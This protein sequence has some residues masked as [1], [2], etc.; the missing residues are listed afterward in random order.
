MTCLDFAIAKGQSGLSSSLGSA[1]AHQ[2]RERRGQ[3]AVAPPASPAIAEF[4]LA[5]L[6]DASLRVLIPFR[7]RVE[8]V[9]DDPAGGF[10]AIAEEI[11]EIG[12]GE[13][14]SEAITDLAT[15]L[16]RPEERAMATDVQI[17]VAR[18]V[19]AWTAMKSQP[20]VT[21]LLESGERMHELPFSYDVPGPTRRVL[22]G[23][24]DCLV[25][26]PDGAIVVIES[27]RVRVRRTTG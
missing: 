8:R 14:V 2:A 5:T 1:E 22:R 25:R 16:I 9:E 7:V 13:T 11:D 15:R 26:R 20:G 27:G 3:D 18:A 6:T 21:D 10:V 12:H 19:A 17:C 4:G 24:I 23:T